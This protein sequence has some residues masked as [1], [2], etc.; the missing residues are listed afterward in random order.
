MTDHVS[1]EWLELSRRAAFASHRL[2]GWIYWDPVAIEHYTNLGP[3]AFSYYISTRG[4]SLA[5]AGNDAVVAAF[6][7]I[8]PEYVTISL[9]NCRVHCSFEA[10]ADARD[11]GVVAGLH[12]YVPEICDELAAIA[13]PL[14]EAANALPRAGR[15]LASTLRERPRSDVPLLSAWLA[16]NC[17]REWRGDTHWAIQTAE[18]LGQVEVGVLDGAWRGYDDQWLARSRGADDHSLV[19]AMSNLE[20]RGLATDG[21]VNEQ[22]LRYRQ[23]LEDRLDGLTSVAWQTLGEARTLEFLALVEPVGHR[24]MERIDVTAGPNWMPAGR[25]RVGS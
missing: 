23:G 21:V 5:D 10:A 6:Y 12:E 14:W 18:D 1:P 19:A 20:Q 4:S 2:I 3:D 7:S 24:L 25:D 22:G 15:V 13:A 9:D 8:A 16:L 11:Q 17:I